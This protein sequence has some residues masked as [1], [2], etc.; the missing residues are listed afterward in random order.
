MTLILPFRTCQAQTYDQG[1]SWPN[2]G[3]GGGN[4]VQAGHMGSALQR[5][6]I[7]PSI[8][9]IKEPVAW[10]DDMARTGDRIAVLGVSSQLLCLMT[11]MPSCP[12]C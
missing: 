4:G 3:V 9:P 12:G 10:L 1:V 8:C 7:S 11:C 6:R 5:P 2:V